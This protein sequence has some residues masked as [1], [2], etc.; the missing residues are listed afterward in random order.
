MRSRDG[1]MVAPE[2][3]TYVSGKEREDAVILKEKR[4]AR[5]EKHLAKSPAPAT[6]KQSGKG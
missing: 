3:K 4:K 2:T 5:E 6:G 1:A